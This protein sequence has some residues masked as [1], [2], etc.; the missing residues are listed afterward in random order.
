MKPS[1]TRAG[2]AAFA[3]EAAVI[4]GTFLAI[5]HNPASSQ[6]QPAVMLS[7]ADVAPPQAQPPAPHPRHEHHTPPPPQPTPPGHPPPPKPP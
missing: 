6:S 7:M 5:A 4:G 1:L 3:L 2:I